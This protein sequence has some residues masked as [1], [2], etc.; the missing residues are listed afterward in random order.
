MILNAYD[1]DGTIYRG[2][3]TKDFYFFCL[4]HYPKIIRALPVQIKGAV[5]F[6]IRLS[7]LKDFKTSFYSFLKYIDDFEKAVSLFWDKYNKKIE[8][9]YLKQKEKDDVIIS[10]SPEFLL[11]EMCQR[12]GV[13][14]L[15]ATKIDPLSGKH[16][17]ENCKGEEKVRRFKEQF[18]SKKI[19]H[20]YYDSKSDL[21]MC[22][23]A[24]FSHI[25]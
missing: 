2:D 22:R 24:D 3:S 6:S 20:F 16:L 18:P 19:N 7:S 17:S 15:I 8:K 12:L 4:F 11:S 10:A 21:P 9:W 13:S 23:L 14:N 5:L 1:F 25:I